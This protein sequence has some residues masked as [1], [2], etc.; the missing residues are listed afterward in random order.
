MNA[1]PVLKNPSADEV[2]QRISLD[3]YVVIEDVMPKDFVARARMELAEAIH[4]EEAWHEGRAYRDQN[5]VLLCALYGGAFWQLFDQESVMAPF[6]AV[7]GPGCIVYAYTSSSMPPGHGNYSTRIHV[8]CPRLIPGYVTNMGATLLVDDFTED[9]GATWFLPGS[10]TLAEPPDEGTFKAQALRLVAPA[11]SGFFF[12]AR[13]WHAGGHNA[14]QQW[15]HAL[16]LNMCRP[17]MKQRID[18]PRALAHQNLTGM[19]SRARQKLGFL[20]QVPASL[21]EY[22][23][24]PS[25][26]KFQQETE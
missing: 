17:Y 23:A 10:H 16:T 24:P 12:N 18:I 5:M 1:A 22:Y 13:L 25:Q 14:S 7:M 2:R 26:R 3:G 19:S 4:K 6:E 20:A 9:N 15:R 21:D 8:D 11:G